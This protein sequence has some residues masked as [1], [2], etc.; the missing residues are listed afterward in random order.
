MTDNGIILQE[1]LQASGNCIEG[2]SASQLF[3]LDAGK[4]LHTIGD[5]T[6]G[7]NKRLKPINNLDILKFN[8]SNLKNSILFSM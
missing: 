2:G 7:S 8:C 5:R 3:G 4:P 6:T 1:P